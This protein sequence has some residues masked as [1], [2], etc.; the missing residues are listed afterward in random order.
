MTVICREDVIGAIHKQRGEFKTADI[1]A[2]LGVHSRRVSGHMEA[3]GNAGRIKRVRKEGRRYIWRHG[4]NW[5]VPAEQ[6]ADD[7]RRYVATV[8]ATS[9]ARLSAATG[10]NGLSA[11]NALEWLH[12]RGELD[13]ERSSMGTMVYRRAA[14]V[15]EIDWQ[16]LGKRAVAC[17]GWRWVPGMLARYTADS[18][19]RVTEANSYG[20]PTKVRPPNSRN[21]WPDLRDAATLGCLLALIR[22][23]VEPARAPG[24]LPLV[25]CQP[26]PKK[27]AVGAF[28]DE[29]RFRALVP[30]FYP[31][32]AEALV[33]A[34]EASQ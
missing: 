17:R 24:D 1:G 4:S 18:W 6:C 25:C 21:A 8:T 2:A 26:M 16:Q 30:P 31:T 33:A 14:P 34:L 3:L 12:E 10:L 32:E 19:C 27:W 13:R 9:T 7:V 5:H 22:Q 15:V 11:Y 23:A 20:Y 28:L 29:S